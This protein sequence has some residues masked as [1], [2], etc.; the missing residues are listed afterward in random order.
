M[1][2]N[3]VNELLHY[4]CENI[5]NMKKIIALS[6][7]SLFTGILLAQPPKGLA[8]AGMIFGEKTTVEGAISS[9]ELTKKL[10]KENKVD[11]KV[12][13]EVS[14]VCA[15]EGCWL[16]MKTETGTIMVK[17]KDHKF[18]VP[19]SMNGKTIVVKG[20]AE[21]KVTSVEMLQHYALDAG[22]TKEEIAAIKTPK[23]EIVVQATGIVVIK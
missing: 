15:A 19:L 22:K 12:E 1:Y 21:K 4:I 11:V 17:M 6:I 5:S 20:I 7:T 8:D 13:G 3:Q 2:E 23:Q 16:K 18:L 10:D 9:N 14:Q